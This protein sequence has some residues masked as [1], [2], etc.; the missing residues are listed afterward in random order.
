[1]KTALAASLALFLMGGPALA[2]SADLPKAIYTDPPRDAAHPAHMEA[3]RIASHGEFMNV[4]VYHPAG[5]GP[6]P[7]ILLIHGLPGNE[8]NLDLAQALR[9]AGWTVFSYHYR[10]SWGSEGRFTIEGTKDDA[11]AMLAAMRDPKNAAAWNIDPKR[12]VV[13]GHS[14]GGYAAGHAGAA[15]SDV[16][17]T[18]LLAPWDPSLDAAMFGPLTPAARDALSERAFDDVEGRLAG[19]DAHAIAAD[20]AAHGAAYRLAD[21]AAGLATRPLLVITAARDNQSCKAPNLKPALAALKDDKVDYAE[22]QADHGFN[23]ARIGLETRVLLWLA[24]LPGA[25]P[26]N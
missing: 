11:D 24:K 1:M 6:H 5:S 19:T 18:V 26:L 3:I 14:L 4:V 12:L 23:E 17:A 16:M 2:Q 8:Q 10:G 22:F 15:N 25:P 9:R 7:A 20:L 13:I 21:D